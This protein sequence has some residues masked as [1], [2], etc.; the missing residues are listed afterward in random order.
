MESNIWFFTLHQIRVLYIYYYYY[1][2]YSTKNFVLHYYVEWML[3]VVL[4]VAVIWI[5]PIGIPLITCTV[6]EWSFLFFSY[7]CT[8]SR[9]ILSKILSIP[10]Y[11]M[12]FVLLLHHIGLNCISGRTTITHLPTTKFLKFNPT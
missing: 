5:N 3:V 7:K 8:H 4:R 2:H 10:F 11:Y 1:Y 9:I 12:L 6:N